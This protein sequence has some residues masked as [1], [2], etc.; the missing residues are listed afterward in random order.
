[1]SQTS[2]G[3]ARRRADSATR[4]SWLLLGI[5]VVLTFVL[6]WIGWWP[7]SGRFGIRGGWPSAENTIFLSLRAFIIDGVY[8]D[9]AFTNNSAWLVAARWTG[10]ATFAWSLVT[11]FITLSQERISRWR[12][13]LSRNHV[14][15][16]GDHPIAQALIRRARQTDQELIHVSDTADEATSSPG[17][18]V[19]P[20][21]VLEG[22][23]DLGLA[24]R[25]DMILIA[26][27]DT[28][29]SAET[30]LNLSRRLPA[31]VTPIRVHLD[32]P[33]AAEGFHHLP[34]GYDI[35]TFSL[36]QGAAREVQLRYPP[37]VLARKIAAS[38]IHVVIVNYGRL[39]E[40]L[41]DEVL[42]NCVSSG[43]DEPWITVL[44]E[45]A[46]RAERAFHARRPE[47]KAIGR[48]RFVPTMDELVRS[49]EDRRAP[50]ACTAYVCVQQSAEAFS[51]AIALREVA[52]REGL[53]EGP[54]FVYLTSG[55]GLPR[56]IEG[57]AREDPLPLLGFGDLDDVVL[58]SQALE[59]DADRAARS[60]NEAYADV[61][62][63]VYGG[64]A[65]PAPWRTLAEPMRV[66][67]RRVITHIPAK[68]ASLGYDLT[69][70][71]EQSLEQRLQLPSLHPA[72]PLFRTE[73]DRVIAAELE[74]R[75]WM[76]DRRLSG[77]RLGPR[78]NRRKF[79]PDFMPF[80]DLSDAVK[81]F[82]Y[83]VND[84]L[85]GILPRSPDGIKR[86]G[87]P[88]P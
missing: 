16:V 60:V 79:H 55:G 48:V 80:D 74:H 33:V 29:A 51:A 30:A 32:D 14:L 20:R 7:L 82:D 62:A 3:G 6:G 63:K 66:S 54:I 36:A 76:A 18:V 88:G 57:A 35:F 68:L 19:L 25:A 12:A 40:G 8:I 47:A 43:L 45:D 53:F 10:A 49:L 24:V 87:E 59:T 81:A 86:L 26:E 83:G 56:R 13:A 5:L 1:M 34:G 50:R 52:Q 84:W 2:D 28:G 65:S 75:R 78:D 23:S 21:H 9:P 31:G 67:N 15:V 37:F 85:D 71:L 27:A 77:W 4:F 46:N 41:I 17:Y 22:D 64:R 11:A 58:V 69:P 42:V 73:A 61:Y 39:A 72:H 44:D 38:A 70:L